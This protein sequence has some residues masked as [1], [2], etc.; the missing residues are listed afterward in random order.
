MNTQNFTMSIPHQLTRAE[1]KRRIQEQ[2]G[3]LKQQYGAMLG[4][5]QEHWEG[6]TMTFTLQV[7]GVTLTGHVHVEDQVVRVDVPLPWPLSMLAG[8]VK[9]QIE[10]HGRKLLGRS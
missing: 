10:Q 6:D 8:T 4:Q 7:T 9:Q 5:V 3:Q 2:V 1:V